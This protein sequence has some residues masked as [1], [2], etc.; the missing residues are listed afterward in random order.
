MY[1]FIAAILPIYLT[2]KLAF[3]SN[4]ATTIFHSFCMVVYFFPIIGAMISDSWF[5]KYKTIFYFL[6]VYL[7]GSSILFGSS[8]IV[9]Q[10]VWR[11]VYTF[12]ISTK[13]QWIF[14]LYNF[15]RPQV[16]AL[17]NHNV[18]R[19]D[20]SPKRLLLYFKVI[21]YIYRSLKVIG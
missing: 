2:T 4:V 18:D 15:R 7:F 6:I 14:R 16:Q 19:N 12:L 11:Y 17:S 10:Y 21:K 13:K 1:F 5:G 9:F 8:L 20:V 3:D